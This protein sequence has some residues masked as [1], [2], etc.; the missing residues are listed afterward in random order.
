MRKLLA[1]NFSRLRKDTVFWLAMLGMTAGSVF[2]SYLNYQTSLRYDSDPIYVEDVLFNLFPM[3]AF[4]C[5]GFISLYL[6]TEFDENTIRNKLIVG[7]TRT[8]VFFANYLTCMVASL[9]LL[10]GILLFSGVTG[11]IFI[12]EFMMDWT[13]LA[14][15]ILCCILCT[16]VFSAICVGFAM[17]IHKKAIAVVAT[18]IFMLGILYL[19]SYMEGALLEAEMTYDFAIITVDGVQFGDLVEN[20]AY[21]GGTAR[22]IMEFIYDMLPTGQAIQLNNMDFERCLRWPWLSAIM[23]VLAT[24]AG[25]LPFRKRDVK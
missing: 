25:Y 3:I 7:H 16:M 10:F 19:A 6:G 4:V 1:A 14:F 9:L 23:L 18:T 5:V 2:F 15:L 24:V 20:P 12:K 17:N 13:Q 22:K 8:E 11:Y 21:I